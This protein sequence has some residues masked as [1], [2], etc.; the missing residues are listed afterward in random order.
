MYVLQKT[1]SELRRI[2]RGITGKMVLLALLIIPILYGALYLWAFLDPYGKLDRLPVALVN[3]DQPYVAS[4]G[5][6]IRGG[7][8]LVK[9]LT[10]TGTF[11]WEVVS[12]KQA[13]QG[14]KDHKYFLALYIPSYF[15]QRIGTANS[16]SPVPAMLYAK[17]DVTNNFLTSQIGGRVFLEI[18]QQTSAKVSETFY[19]EIFKS[20]EDSRASL[21]KAEDGAQNLH[22]G[23]KT[24]SSGAGS[25]AK[26]LSSAKSGSTSLASGAT[27]LARG[28]SKLNSGS[29]T[30]TSSTD[31]L[32]YK[33]QQLK[34]GASQ[35][36]SGTSA[37]SSKLPSLVSGAKQVD[38]GVATLQAQMGKASNGATALA[39]GA[40]GNKQYVEGLASVVSQLL[41]IDGSQLPAA[42][43]Q[44]MLATAQAAKAVAA[45]VDSGASQLSGSLSSAA[46]AVYAL[47]SGTAQLL[48]GVQAAQNGALALKNGAASLDA[49][50]SK[51]VS[52]T[53][54]LNDGAQQISNNVSKASAGAT[55]L[56]SGSK[57][58]TAGTAKLEQGAVKLHSGL[59]PAVLGSQTLSRG[60]HDGIKDI[61]SL[62]VAQQNENAKMMSNPVHM[63]SSTIGKAKNYGTGFAP[64]FLPLAL[65][66]GAL[67]GYMFLD[68]LPGKSE[69]KKSLWMALA[70]SISGYVPMALVAF[71]QTLVLL[72]V[73]EHMLHINPVRS[74]WFWALL[75]ATSLCYTAILQW[76]NASFGPVGKFF[77]IIFLMLQLTAASGTFPTV[78]QDTF[79]QSLHPFMPMTYIVAGL[80]AAMNGGSTSIITHNLAV[81]I[82]IGVGVFVLTIV[83]AYTSLSEHAKR[84]GEKVGI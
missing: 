21:G 42:Q 1:T 55:T 18:Q 29:K 69:K 22:N 30:L 12:K 83:A 72:F 19:K 27:Q 4:N 84:L 48:S 65:W 50:T 79:F 20:F 8:D 63:T 16:K 9:E 13:Q 44:Q 28:L 73:V 7:E 58:L 60:L 17:S 53:Q 31:E 77:A 57:Q 25:L 51:L 26:G 34:G 43:K 80:R 76:L 38:G 59:Q 67:I 64:Y 24:A 81:V 40:A 35:L 46:P 78:L 66:V 49:G 45:Q 71:L 39:Q 3:Q 47:K 37:L 68:P 33:S 15:S 82:G 6:V 11:K 70:R 74:A 5:T 56:A 62:T 54:K 32:A 75:L 14:L 10:D 41:S 36:L 23:L 61:P 2:F 52:G